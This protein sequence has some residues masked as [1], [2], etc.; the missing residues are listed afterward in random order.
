LT[1]TINSAPEAIICSATRSA[2]GAPTAQ[3][4][5]PQGIPAAAK[6]YIVLW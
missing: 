6:R 2:Y 3:P 4:T 1:L 5:M